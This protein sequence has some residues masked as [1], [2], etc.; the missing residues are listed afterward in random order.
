LVL[1]KFLQIQRQLQQ[2][3]FQQIASD[4]KK[5]STSGYFAVAT[6]SNA[7]QIWPVYTPFYMLH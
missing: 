4:G 7:T 6:W 5:F 1:A 3:F 2:P